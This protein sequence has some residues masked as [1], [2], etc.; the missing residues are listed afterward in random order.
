MPAVSEYLIFGVQSFKSIP[1]PITLTLT[2]PVDGELA[3]TTSAK[4]GASTESTLDK[5]PN[6]MAAVNKIDNEAL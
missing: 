5:D 3:L 2:A 6:F 4:D 1:S